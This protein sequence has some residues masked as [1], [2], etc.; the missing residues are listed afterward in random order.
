M[1]FAAN[2]KT[3][4]SVFRIALL[5]FCL[6]ALINMWKLAC[7]FISWSDCCVRLCVVQSADVGPRSLCTF[8]G[9][10]GLNALTGWCLLMSGTSEGTKAWLGLNFSISDCNSDIYGASF[11]H[12]HTR[13][14]CHVFLC[15]VWSC[16]V[17]CSSRSVFLP[18][19]SPNAC[20]VCL[21]F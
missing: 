5:C 15:C 18:I 17:L 13:S 9:G 7:C 4:C 11:Q 3:H 6:C 20:R 2:L 21:F 19:C 8:C 16:C 10:G 12:T 1:P 14:Y